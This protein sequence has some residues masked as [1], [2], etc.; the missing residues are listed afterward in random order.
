MAAIDA[1]VELDVRPERPATVTARDLSRV[2]GTA[3]WS[4][5]GGSGGGVDGG[6]ATRGL[7]I[8]EEVLTNATRGLVG[9]GGAV[10]ELYAA[11]ASAARFGVGEDGALHGVAVAGAAVDD[12]GA[13]RGLPVVD[14]LLRKTDVAK[15]HV[16][17]S[18]VVDVLPSAPYAILADGPDT[19]ILV[20]IV[21]AAVAVGGGGGGRHCA[22]EMLCEFVVVREIKSKASGDVFLRFYGVRT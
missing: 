7:A 5:G 20:V 14:Q 13:T 21:A 4:D 15:A 16:Q 22:G 12:G 18:D 6:G 9:A 8:A 11:L 3:C 2:E 1:V 19:S 10:V 17:V